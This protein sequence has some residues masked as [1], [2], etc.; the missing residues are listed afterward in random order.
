MCCLFRKANCQSQ[1]STFL[2]DLCVKAPSVAQYLVQ[3]I[4]NHSRDDSQ[5]EVQG[6]EELGL[7]TN[8]KRSS[9]RKK[10][11]DRTYRLPKSSRTHLNIPRDG[12]EDSH[13]ASSI[14]SLVSDDSV[15]CQ[16]VDDDMTINQSSDSLVTE[17]PLTKM[18]G[19]YSQ[20]PCRA[21]SSGRS[22]RPVCCPRPL[23][24]QRVSATSAKGYVQ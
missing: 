17:K 5:P 9:K 11:S 1:F 7:C 16:P 23:Y 10:P 18:R 20:D 12:A 4:H 15:T 22:A 21:I 6:S 2:Q 19:A 8:S 3:E 13:G 14:S 24:E